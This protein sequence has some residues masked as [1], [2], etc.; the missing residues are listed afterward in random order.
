[1]SSGIDYIPRADIEFGKWTGI[2]VKNLGTMLSRLHIP[3]EVHAELVTLNDDFAQK[4]TLALEPGTRTKPVVV[5]KNKARRA[6]NKAVRQA[7][8]EHLTY[9]QTLT[10]ADREELDLPI[11][12]ST[13]TPAPVAASYPMPE[14]ECSLIRHLTIHFYDAERMGTG[15]KAKPV[16]QLG[17]EIVWAIR[18][19]PPTEV[20]D[21][22]HSTFC[23]HTPVTLEFEE[24]ERGKTVYFSLCWMNTR[25]KQ[26][27][28][29]GIKSAIIP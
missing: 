2:F 17:A 18:D 25:A 12:K 26:G 4:L 10:D 11:H 9:N 21:L 13:H 28:W 19:T 16:G 7:V 3:P 24:D 22:T 6:L 14:V 27:P 8:K 15:T 23:T 1:M 5:A 29:S 20:S